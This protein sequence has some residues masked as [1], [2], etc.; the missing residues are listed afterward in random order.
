MDYTWHVQHLLGEFGCGH[1]TD[2]FRS[3]YMTADGFRKKARRTAKAGSGIK[4][5]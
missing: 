2:A 1:R 3:S 4:Y 5:A